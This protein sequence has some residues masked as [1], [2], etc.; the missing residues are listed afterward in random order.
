ML[1]IDR[2]GANDTVGNGG[3]RRAGINQEGETISPIAQYRHRKDATVV[4]P[5][6]DS[7]A[8]GFIG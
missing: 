1:Q 8:A 6:G 4:A 5:T 7:V 3:K 2:Q